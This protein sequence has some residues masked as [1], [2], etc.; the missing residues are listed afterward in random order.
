MKMKLEQWLEMRGKG[1]RKTY[2]SQAR[3]RADGPLYGARYAQREATRRELEA[4]PAA[5]DAI[6]KR[7]EAEEE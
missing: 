4:L 6:K 5:I 3:R 2:H 7:R 1:V